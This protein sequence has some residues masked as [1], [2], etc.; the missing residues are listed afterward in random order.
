MVTPERLLDVLREFSAVD[1]RIWSGLQS[2]PT[3]MKLLFTIVDAALVNRIWKPPTSTV[4]EPERFQ[5]GGVG[6]MPCNTDGLLKARIVRTRGEQRNLLCGGRQRHYKVRTLP[7]I[8]V[9]IA[10][11]M[12]SCDRSV[13]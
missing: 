10:T 3:N 4:V 5:G 6:T 9:V 13:R 7:R 1:P 11:I 2:E 12:L 8:T